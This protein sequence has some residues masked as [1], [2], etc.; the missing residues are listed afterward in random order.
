MVIYTVI[1]IIFRTIIL[2]IFMVDF[3]SFWIYFLGKKGPWLGSPKLPRRIVVVF[4]AVPL[5]RHH[6]A[7]RAAGTGGGRQSPCLVWLVGGVALLLVAAGKW[8]TSEDTVGRNALQNPQ[9]RKFNHLPKKSWSCPPLRSGLAKNF[10]PSPGDSSWHPT[11]QE[12]ATNFPPC[13]CLP[14]SL[15]RRA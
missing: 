1:S 8:A 12:G 6:R 11:V 14:A 7:S 10:V 9:G 3:S 4:R 2:G 13:V 5:P 15:R